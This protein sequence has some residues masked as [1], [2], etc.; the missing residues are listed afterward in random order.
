[1]QCAFGIIC[2]V[3]ER[4]PT[5]AECSIALD[6]IAK[7]FG[8]NIVFGVKVKCTS[9]KNMLQLM[10]YNSNLNDRD[11]HCYVIDSYGYNI[12]VQEL[13]KV[14][15]KLYPHFMLKPCEFM[16]LSMFTTDFKLDRD[17][18]AVCVLK[19]IR[20]AMSCILA[21]EQKCKL[22]LY[23]EGSTQRRPSRTDYS[24]VS[25]PDFASFTELLV[26]AD[27]NANI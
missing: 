17:D 6:N 21:R 3:V 2:Y 16:P 25:T 13:N 19:C 5:P 14:F 7:A 9:Q 27:L 1:M 8:K 12:A 24:I 18:V 22:S 10:A 26:W 4:L 11:P 15:S 23:A 20:K